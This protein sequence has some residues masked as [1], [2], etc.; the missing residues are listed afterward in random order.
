MKKSLR[1]SPEL[2]GIR[3]LA[4]LLV[5]FYHFIVEV[6]PVPKSAG[7]GSR[8]IAMLAAHD[9]VT[10]DAFFVLSGF[11]ITALLLADKEQS[12]YF[13]NFYWRRVLRIMPVF[14]ITIAIFWHA[15]PGTGS[16]ILICLFFLGNFGDKFGIRF[17]SPLWTLAI[18]EQFYLFWPHVV[19]R[20]R[21]V[22]VA[23]IGT[24]LFVIT[25]VLRPLL[26]CVFHRP[27]DVGHTY[28]RLDGIGLGVLAACAYMTDDALTP[29]LQGVMKVLESDTLL[30]IWV[31]GFLT[32]PVFPNL[33]WYA[34]TLLSI[35]L[36]NYLI[37]RFIFAVLKKRRRFPGL[38]SKP[39]LYMGSIS[40]SFYLFHGFV[41][42]HFVTHDGAPDVTHV[43]TFLGRMLLVYA[44]TIA[45]STASLYLVEKPA[46]RLRR[47]I[48]ARPA[49]IG[50]SMALK[51]PHDPA[52]YK[53]K[54]T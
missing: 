14:L 3:G 21:V 48:L 36:T 17:L 22:T 24:G 11:L 26:F 5:C 54:L 50:E 31:A 15:Y 51:V 28:Y 1:Y 35:S 12:H 29:A 39:M 9:Y 23:W 43:W 41:I 33:P 46:Q 13:Y 37:F 45:A 8:I 30:Y 53:R 19:R 44:V 32:L 18:E 2:A 6:A 52:A 49:D 40:Y 16:Y 25:T 38:G 27:V 10:V 34:Q 47:Y 7:F 42:H 20:C 4:A